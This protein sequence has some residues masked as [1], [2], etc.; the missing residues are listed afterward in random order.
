L[1]CN[2][3]ATSAL[4]T[5]LKHFFPQLINHVNSY[6]W[7]VWKEA[8]ELGI[9][10]GNAEY[11]GW[12]WEEFVK[13]ARDHP[14]RK[15]LVYI[16]ES[17]DKST[18]EYD[19]EVL[20]PLQEMFAKES[21]PTLK[22]QFGAMFRYAR[23]RQLTAGTPGPKDR[24]FLPPNMIR[25]LYIVNGS[26]PLVA[27]GPFYGVSNFR[28][29]WPLYI[30]IPLGDGGVDLN[31]CGYV[32]HLQGRWGPDK[33]TATEGPEG[34]KA[35]KLRKAI[36]CRLGQLQMQQ[37]AAHG[38]SSPPSSP[39]PPLSPA[40][41]LE[42][43]ESIAPASASPAPSPPAAPDG[44]LPQLCEEGR[45]PPTQPD[46][47]KAVHG[48]AGRAAAAL[49]WTAVVALVLVLVW[50][51]TH[52]AWNRLMHAL[53][54]N[55]SQGCTS[56]ASQDYLALPPPP[57]P[58]PVDSYDALVD[59]DEYPRPRVQRPPTAG[60]ARPTVDAEGD[61]LIWPPVLQLWGLSG[62]I[63]NAT[64]LK[65]QFPQAYKWELRHGVDGFTR[66]A[67]LSFCSPYDAERHPK[68]A[69]QALAVA[70]E[71]EMWCNS[72]EARFVGRAALVTVGE[73][74][75]WSASNSAWSKTVG[76]LA[77]GAMPLAWLFGPGTAFARA[78]HTSFDT[79]R[80]RPSA[81][82]PAPAPASA[83][84]PAPARAHA[85][86]PAPAPASNPA[87][88]SAPAPAPAPAH[89]H[90]SA[91]APTP[92]SHPAPA[93]APPHSMGSRVAMAHPHVAPPPPPRPRPPPPPLPPSSRVS[94]VPPASVYAPAPAPAP[95]P[96][97]THACAPAPAP[98]P[99]SAPARAPTLRNPEGSRAAAAPFCMAPPPPPPRSL[100]PPPLP[101]LLGAE[102][103]TA[104]EQSAQPCTYE[105]RERDLLE[106]LL[107]RRSW[108]EILDV[109][110]G[111]TEEGLQ[112]AFVRL[113][114]KY[115]PLSMG[116]GKSIATDQAVA[117]RLLL[118][119]DVM[120]AHLMQPALRQLHETSIY[121]DTTPAWQ[122]EPL[123]LRQRPIGGGGVPPPP[124]YGRPPPDRYQVREEREP[125]A[126]HQVEWPEDGPLYAERRRARLHAR[127][128]PTRGRHSPPTVGHAG[129]PSGQP[130][131]LRLVVSRG[132]VEWTEAVVGDKRVRP[133]PQGMHAGSCGARAA[134][135]A[136]AKRGYKDRTNAKRTFQ[137]ATKSRM[138]GGPSAPPS[139]PDLL[140]ERDGHGNEPCAA[141]PKAVHGN[142]GRAA[143]ALVWTAVVALVLVLVWHLTHA[144]WNRLM[145]ALHGNTSQGCSQPAFAFASH[146]ACGSGCEVP[147]CSSEDHMQ[148]DP[149][150]TPAC[151]RRTDGMVVPL[152]CLSIAGDYDSNG[153]PDGQCEA[154]LAWS[155]ECI[156]MVGGWENGLPRGHC[157]LQTGGSPST[158][159]SLFTERPTT[160][161]SLVTERPT[162]PD[163][164]TFPSRI[165]P[166]YLWPVLDPR[167]NKRVLT[168][169]MSVS[170]D[171]DPAGASGTRTYEVKGVKNKGEVSLF[172]VDQE[173]ERVGGEALPPRASG[174]V[175]EECVYYGKTVTLCLRVGKS[176]H[177]S[178]I[179][180]G[181]VHGR[182]GF[183]FS[184]SG[185]GAL[186]VPDST[187][188][189]IISCWGCLRG[190]W[191][192]D[193]FVVEQ[194]RSSGSRTQRQQGASLVT[195]E[196]PSH[197]LVKEATECHSCLAVYNV[198]I[199][200]KAG[201]G[202]QCPAKE[203][204][205]PG[206]PKAT[207]A[208][209]IHINR[210][211]AAPSVY[212]IG[213]DGRRVCAFVSTN[214]NFASGQSLGGAR[215]RL[216]YVEC[217]EQSPGNSLCFAPSCCETLA[218]RLHATCPHLEALRKAVKEERGLKGGLVASR[219]LS[220]DGFLA[221]TGVEDISAL[222]PR[223][224]SVVY[225]ESR[226]GG[227]MD[228]GGEVL[229]PLASSG[230][231]EDEDEEDEEDEEDTKVLPTDVLFGYI[232]TVADILDMPRGRMAAIVRSQGW[233]ETDQTKASLRY[234]L[235]E[236]YHPSEVL[237]MAHVDQGKTSK[238]QQKEGPKRRREGRR[239]S[240]GA[241]RRKGEA[242]LSSAIL[243]FR[244][245]ER[246]RRCKSGSMCHESAVQRAFA[247]ELNQEISP[248]SETEMT[249]A[250]IVAQLCLS[251]D[252]IC[253]Y[254]VSGCYGLGSP[255]IRIGERGV[256][257][258]D[259]LALCLK[260]AKRIYPDNLADGAERGEDLGTTLAE[261]GVELIRIPV[262]IRYNVLGPVSTDFTL[263]MARTLVC[264]HLCCP[265]LISLTLAASHFLSHL[266]HHCL[267]SH[268]RRLTPPLQLPRR[269]HLPKLFMSQLPRPHRGRSCGRR[270]QS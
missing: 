216:A 158:S 96:A 183:P 135:Q 105:S 152:F 245:A 102:R 241:H 260:C 174:G 90:A 67:V 218:C 192:Q 48:N 70:R 16:V 68:M 242:D 113:R 4:V 19:K 9:K 128:G 39:P 181:S 111:V 182:A 50:H 83:P 124:S 54:G 132:Q 1:L 175:F 243:A 46:L 43:S 150:Q 87:P 167:H 199:A 200:R 2:Q 79:A 217:D 14:S 107:D 148:V 244:R 109:R 98:A 133:G 77:G 262:G 51:L 234:Q 255:H 137:R 103:A 197:I 144:A 246:T 15:A 82:N 270:L 233:D 168:V 60:G 190:L 195:C 180:S 214:L 58:P 42:D 86:A 206:Q 71:T 184:R 122:L 189:N 151:L 114:H 41:E 267:H 203:E 120:H 159:V 131:D 88:A 229:I 198:D 108:Y 211:S 84:A 161:V 210:S 61:D 154:T 156:T 140:T 163:Y 165:A 226:S 177:T 118:R 231:D 235:M 248:D 80:A 209:P 138:A 155:A 23:D 3:Y 22:K 117:Q 191:W 116:G 205:Y 95:A 20:K 213:F 81:S 264:G 106:G 53:H 239:K 55:T 129:R 212:I 5:L 11:R 89:A 157:T 258:G 47:P 93:P 18:G 12:T 249:A 223:Q 162:A 237:L 194:D 185:Q 26:E 268:S 10:P 187:S 40:S 91:P 63:D 130:Q 36:L 33:L 29:G 97:T 57:P 240:G 169:S 207:K 149:S 45:C 31:E 236:H 208:R 6:Q 164:Q 228:G 17:R 24:R 269:R 37:S 21:C 99:D 265:H 232:P 250:S 72:K 13:I 176:L 100:P 172:C 179:Y 139:P 215:G 27:G 188:S 202:H 94:E 136:A 115:V 251:Q 38:T 204:V 160:S 32:G 65:R 7:Q 35:S 52:A 263:T 253:H 78:A 147:D 256:L 125:T 92:A 123:R 69:H 62:D 193:R 74:A 141:L 227:E 73:Q 259:H 64:A 56:A 59:T 266:N 252:S 247:F 110:P 219:G 101:L 119:L 145:H 143:A 25:S 257:M 30:T 75:R 166:G 85:S 196:V 104:I 224:C 121:G 171:S 225:C 220:L 28:H 238:G 44:E 222:P 66:Q 170:S 34:V 126:T 146:T 76:K 127:Q 254:G 178:Y 8:A 221:L 142:A 201:R 173:C 153:L 261:M 186:Y 134:T 49:V 230:E 112:R